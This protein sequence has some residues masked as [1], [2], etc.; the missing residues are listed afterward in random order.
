[1]NR[2][3]RHLFALNVTALSDATILSC[4]SHADA[5]VRRLATR[6]AINRG[7]LVTVKR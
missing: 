4:V 2:A 5:L 7:L 6:E 3:A 1:M